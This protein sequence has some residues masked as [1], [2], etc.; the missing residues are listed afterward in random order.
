M[1]AMFKLLLLLTVAAIYLGVG[2]KF[3]AVWL[4]CFQQD[5]PSWRSSQRSKYIAAL[6]IA[7]LFWVAIV[8]LNYLELLSAQKPENVGEF[9]QASA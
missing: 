8:P 4:N 9:E 7:A 3:F 2:L 1:N 5:R 6:V